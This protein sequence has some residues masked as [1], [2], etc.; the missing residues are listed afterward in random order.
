MMRL[1]RRFSMFASVGAVGT[2]LH[3]AVL[4]V[5]VEYLGVPAPIAAAFGAFIGAAFNYLLNYRFTFRSSARHGVAVPRFATVAFLGLLINW[6]IVAL[7]VW[8]GVHSMI[9]QIVATA[10]VLV[11]GFLANQVWT[12]VDSRKA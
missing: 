4:F 8:L 6:S 2:L 3:Y 12:F 9:G 7:A 10:L 5:L 11:L 1:L